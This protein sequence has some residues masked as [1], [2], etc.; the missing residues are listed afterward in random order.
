MVLSFIWVWTF[1]EMRLCFCPELTEIL[2]SE[3]HQKKVSGY[4]LN[5]SQGTENICPTE[6]IWIGP[7]NKEWYFCFLIIVS[8]CQ[9]LVFQPNDFRNDDIQR[10]RNIQE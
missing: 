5:F 6:Q 9:F 8:L 2:W 4:A 7:K 3:N 10:Y 1:T